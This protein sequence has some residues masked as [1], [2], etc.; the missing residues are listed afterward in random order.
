MESNCGSFCIV[1]VF[2]NAT[3]NQVEYFVG[4]SEKYHV[5]AV[6]NSDYRQNR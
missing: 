1:V 6:D 3:E 4:L 2:Y 5:I